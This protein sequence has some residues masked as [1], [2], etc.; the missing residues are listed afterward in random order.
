LI[1]FYKRLHNIDFSTNT[2]INT[3]R[4]T[5]R[6]LVI[7][8]CIGSALARPDG[9]GG[10]HEH[11]AAAAPATGYQQ[12][13]ASYSEP[14][15]GYEQPTGYAAPSGGSGYEQ[16]GYD[17]G[18]GATGYSSGYGVAE[19][20][21]IDMNMLLIPVLILAGLALL[22]P[23]VTTVAVRKKRDADDVSGNTIVDRVQDIYMSVMQSEECMER[24]AC[25]VGGIVDDTGL[26]KN[27]FNV[28]EGFVPQ[29]YSKMMKRFNN[30][31]D[32][33]KIKCGV[34]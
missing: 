15:S 30:A 29:K 21:G 18:Y 11:H 12:P 23:S 31:K 4:N 24:I 28:A 17:S 3:N 2:H 22:F 33:H 9:A 34:F 19:D 10:H 5:M 20:S 6:Y 14:A 32:C 8:V 26:S 1:H 7:A 25:E 27:L 16:P 13:S